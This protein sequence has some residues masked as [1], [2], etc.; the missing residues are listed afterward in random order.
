M[1]LSNQRA[2]LVPDAR[3]RVNTESRSYELGWIL[4]VLSGAGDLAGIG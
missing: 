1:L 2:G 4:Y 3:L